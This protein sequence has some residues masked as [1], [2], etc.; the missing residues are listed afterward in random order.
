MMYLR[1]N[2]STKIWLLRRKRHPAIERSR[3]PLATGAG[4]DADGVSGALDGIAETDFLLDDEAGEADAM[5]CRLI[6]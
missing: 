1:E 6:V 2:F 5:G 3:P 4:P